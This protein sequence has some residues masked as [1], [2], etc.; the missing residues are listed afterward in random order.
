MSFFK[1]KTV[2][3][4]VRDENLKFRVFSKS[5]V[6]DFQYYG[7]LNEEQSKDPEWVKKAS[8]EIVNAIVA[9]LDMGDKE[10]PSFEDFNELSH[11]ELMEIL[12]KI[13][14]SSESLKK[15]NAK[16]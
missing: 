16:K 4:F 5:T 6:E 11:D 14:G 1:S 3:H 9:H 12:S 13:S 10:A 8:D 15:A 7:K 2:S